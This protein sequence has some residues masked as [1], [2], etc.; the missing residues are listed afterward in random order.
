[1]DSGLAE[2]PEEPEV[3]A[4][5]GWA[6]AE[7]DELASSP[8]LPRSDL[9]AAARPATQEV[10]EVPPAPEAAEE[11][12]LP[13]E[14]REPEESAP[15]DP[16]EAEE[17]LPEDAIVE[18]TSDESWEPPAAAL[19][20]WGTAAPLAAAAAAPAW[21]SPSPLAA[22]AA[23]P[24]WGAPVPLAAAAA[25]PAWGAA[26][27][28]TPVEATPAQD[29]PWEVPEGSAKAAGDGW[30]IPEQAL[31]APLPAPADSLFAPL[32][33]GASLSEPEPLGPADAEPVP[34]PPLA[35]FAPPAD[36]D[37]LVPVVEPEGPLPTG[38]LAVLG[39]HRV[40]ITTRGSRTLR[41]F[42]RD[43][44]LAAPTFKLHPVNGGGWESVKSEE[45]K[46]IF[47]MLPPGE[48][49]Q[50]PVGARVKVTFAADGRSIEG[51]RDG[52]DA[53]SGFFLVPADAAKT[54]TRRIFVA[55]AGLSEVV[56]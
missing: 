10:L 43:V 49:P 19:D 35:A 5:E 32:A 53:P 14:A 39:E 40:A 20:A 8:P 9:A 16:A 37:L 38:P 1:M 33:P 3:A 25:A 47:F 22:T 21:G 55:R 2:V 54:K 4:P 44:D 56:G 48:K 46:V 50:T 7:E 11:P 12:G 13:L 24:A 42:L 28:G 23:V 52:E 30:S 15:T 29:D 34:Q 26:G 45:V 17:P 27:W 6:S 51:H 18:I 36:E 41:G 31:S